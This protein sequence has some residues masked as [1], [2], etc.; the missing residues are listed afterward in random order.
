[1]MMLTQF[2]YLLQREPFLIEGVDSLRPVELSDAV[3]DLLNIVE[4]VDAA[5][6][7][8][9]LLRLHRP[10]RPHAVLGEVYLFQHL[11]Q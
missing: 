11:A 5:V 3:E 2:H 7:V 9:V 10:Q 4:Q 8:V 1:M 6:G